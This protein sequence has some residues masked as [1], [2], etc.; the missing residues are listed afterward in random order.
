MNSLIVNDQDYL[1][2]GTMNLDHLK[3]SSG[4]KLSAPEGKT[5][6]MTLNGNAERILPGKYSGNIILNVCD[7]IREFFEHGKEELSYR[8]AAYINDGKFIPEKSVSSAVTGTVGDSEAKNIT[9]KGNDFDFNGILVDGDSEYT[10]SNANIDL[11]GNGTN[12]FMGL[13][14]AIMAYGNSKVLIEDCNI[15]T[16]GVCRGA[17]YAGANAELTVKRCILESETTN[18]LPIGYVDHL[19]LGTSYT[20]TWPLGF[21][22]SCRTCYFTDNA[23]VNIEDCHVLTDCWGSLS[24]DMPKKVRMNVKNTIVDLTGKNCYGAFSIG[25]CID[26]FDHCTFNVTTGL[27]MASNEASGIFKNGCIVNAKLGVLIYR[28]YTGTLDVLDGCVFNTTAASIVCKGSCS[29][30]NVQGCTFNP[31]NGVVFQLMDNDEQPNVDG[32]YIDPLGEEDIHI[33]GRDITW[34]DPEEDV[35]LKYSDMEINGNI[36]NSTTNLLVNQRCPQFEMPWSPPPGPKHSGFGADLQGPKNLDIV[37]DNVKIRGMISSSEARHNTVTVTR[38]NYNELSVVNNTVSAPVNNGVIVH[39]TGGS[40]WTVT[41]SCWITAMEISEDSYVCAPEGK[42]L[43]MVV[44]N[45]ETPVST[46]TYKGMIQL[47]VS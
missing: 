26:T 8:A 38:Y 2:A 37:F 20:V 14:T 15:H 27:M 36:F 13:G 21:D 3:I 16:K 7:D 47:I 31:E 32:Y 30:I 23:T 25:N 29:S 41:E 42:T 18:E 24:V 6:T 33:E 45:H 35:F 44:N 10:I 34:A 46:G 40:S 19:G 43:K 22:G 5:L 28:N 9:I 12:D 17:L 4:S 1:V 39:L 11:S